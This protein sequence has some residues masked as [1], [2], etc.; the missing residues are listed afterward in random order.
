MPE[1]LI[2]LLAFI[3]VGTGIVGIAA[4]IAMFKSPYRH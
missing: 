1:L 2:G 3:T 4:G